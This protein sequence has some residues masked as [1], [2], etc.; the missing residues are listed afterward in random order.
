VFQEQNT[1]NYRPLYLG[2]KRDTLVVN[3]DL[4]NYY[5]PPNI[6]ELIL[7][8]STISTIGEVDKK[9]IRQNHDNYSNYFQDLAFGKKPLYWNDSNIKITIDTTQKTRNIGREK[10][11]Y[12]DF[13]H[14]AYP[15]ILENTSDSTIIIGYGSQIPLILEVKDKNGDWK[16]TEHMFTYMCGNGLPSILLPKGEIVLTSVPIIEGGEKKEFRLRIGENYSE[17]FL[18]ETLSH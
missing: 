18:G 17:E 4:S 9:Q 7:V 12:T 15:V 1:A 10:Y 8:D 6:V 3:Y 16:A 2:I 14:Q 13:I 11:G 5:S